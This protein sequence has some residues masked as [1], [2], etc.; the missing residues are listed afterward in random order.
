MTAPAKANAANEA[1]CRI[2][3]GSVEEFFDFGRQPVS[4]AFV[5]P[6]IGRGASS[7]SGSPRGSARPARW[8]SCWTR[9]RGSGCSTRT[10]RTGRPVRSVMREHFEELRAAPAGDRADRRR[11]RSS[12]RSAATTA[13]MLRT[14]AEAGR[15]APRRGPVAAAW[16]SWPGPRVSGSAPTFFEESPR[17]RDPRRARPGATSS[18]RRTRSCHIAYIDSI[19]RGRRR[20]AR[21]AT[22]SSCFEDRYL[23]DI[24]ERNCLRPDLRRALLSASPSR[25][26]RRWP[27]TFGFE[28]VDV[29]QLAVHGGRDP[30]H[31]RPPGARARRRRRG[32][33]ARRGARRGLAEPGDVRAVRRR[34]CERIRDD[35]VGAA[36]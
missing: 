3:G 32:G 9:C 4:D 7:S 2:C 19:F 22:A 28:L 29:E 34:T 25:R 11:T 36:A 24:V 17:P 12:S 18:S 35:L 6:D 27:S 14:I 26:C 31:A 30:L 1:R 10:T 13:S 21:A 8:C 5:T 15:P 33:A 16:P 23:G 20:A